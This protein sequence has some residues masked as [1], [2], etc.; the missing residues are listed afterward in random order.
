M[1]SG[2]LQLARGLPFSRER[3][4]PRLFKGVVLPNTPVALICSWQT[5]VMTGE[6]REASSGGGPP[7]W[8]ALLQ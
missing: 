2:F 3:A 1:G 7:S 8:T 4:V 6:A 5:F